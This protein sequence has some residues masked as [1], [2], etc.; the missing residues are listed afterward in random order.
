[1]SVAA[2]AGMGA[3]GERRFAKIYRISAAVAR[4]HLFVGNPIIVTFY[5]EDTFH[6]GQE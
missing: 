6:N 2:S 3:G 1:M 5:P 4:H